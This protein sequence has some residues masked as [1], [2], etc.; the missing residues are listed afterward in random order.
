MSYTSNSEHLAYPYKQHTG[1]FSSACLC[2]MKF[3][4]IFICTTMFK[5]FFAT[6]IFLGELHLQIWKT[7]YHPQCFIIYDLDQNGTGSG[8]CSSSFC[9][10]LHETACISLMVFINCY[11]IVN[12]SYLLCGV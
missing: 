6:K 12:V 10:D 5:I 3:N 1:R 11:K 9:K 4:I 7:R 2:K 8:S